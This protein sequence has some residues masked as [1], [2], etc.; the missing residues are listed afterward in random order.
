MVD[1]LVC[2]KICCFLLAHIWD[3]RKAYA[4]SD[5]RRNHRPSDYF[6]IKIKFIYFLNS[7]VNLVNLAQI[8]LEL[9]ISSGSYAST[10]NVLSFNEI[11]QM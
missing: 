11:I 7:T 8:V 3:P 2:N 5:S 1:S 10:V 9:E 6:Y 4:C